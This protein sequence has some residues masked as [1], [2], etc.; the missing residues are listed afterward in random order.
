MLRVYYSE[1]MKLNE[2]KYE[3]L[4]EV[5]DGN[6]SGLDAFALKIEDW[7]FEPLFKKGDFL[8]FI[9]QKG[10]GILRS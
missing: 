2:M 7:Q 6:L 4:E 9:K 8:L 10:I 5:D 3:M 1:A